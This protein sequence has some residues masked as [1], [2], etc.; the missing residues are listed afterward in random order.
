MR[1]PFEFAGEI[2]GPG[3]SRRLELPVARL[4]TQTQLHIPVIVVH[5][6]EPGPVAWVSAALH[7]DE[8]NGTEVIRRVVGTLDP[9]AF[10]GT[11]LAVPIV[12]VFGFLAQ[13]RY[14]PDRRDLNRSF[15][16]RARGNLAGRI[17]HLF[18]TE[19]VE[20]SDFGIDL[21][22]GSNQRTNLPQIRCDVEDPRSRALAE[23]FAAPLTIHGRGPAGTL[24]RAA[25]RLGKP[26]LLYEGGEPSRFDNFAIEYGIRGVERVLRYAGMVAG[27]PGNHPSTTIVQ[28]TR[29]VRASRSGILHLNVGLGDHVG[30]RQ[31]LGTL[32]GAYGE[33]VAYVVASR[34]GV[35]LGMATNP[36]VH[37][38]EA[39][40]HIACDVRP[41]SSA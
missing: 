37:Q 10:R 11:L 4:I 3:R 13:S 20:R 27:E 41:A 23:A 2:V 28:E 40:V 1:S 33:R 25:A 7:G 30:R 35:V 22:T 38:G 18:L 5:G 36:L 31:Q 39:V 16:G 12:N 19:I 29:W 32:L 34:S 15:P 9:A 8:L 17:A 24:R 26:I 6:A 21:H 14:L